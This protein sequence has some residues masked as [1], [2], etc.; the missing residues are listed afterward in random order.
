VAT[1]TTF[2]INHAGVSTGPNRFNLYWSMLAFFANGGGNCFVIS[3]GSYWTNQSPVVSPAPIP[4]TW[5]AGLIKAD[6]S[7]G[8]SLRLRRYLP[9]WA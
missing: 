7:V 4:S 8:T 2:D 3:V 9:Y 1:P 5:V 6:S